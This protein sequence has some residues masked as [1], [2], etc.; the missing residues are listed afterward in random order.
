M[1]S[2]ND[3]V[4]ALDGVRI[5]DFTQVMMGPLATQS[6]GD[7]G[8]NVIKVERPGSGDIFRWAVTDEAG[9]DHPAFLG[10]N[11][12]KRSITI[13]LS[14]ETGHQLALDLA[15][16]S[17]VVINNFRPGIMDKLGLDYETLKTE[18]PR[19]IFA[20]GSG[21][22]TTG[23]YVAKGG[24]DILAQAMT[25]VMARKQDPS[26]PTAIYPTSLADYSAGMHL[27]QGILLALLARERTGRGQYLEVS[28]YDALLAMQSLEAPVVNSRDYDL[29][30]AAFPL[31]GVFPTSD[32]ELVLVGAF[33]KNPLQLICMALSLVDLSLDPR[34]D[35]NESQTV[36]KAEL[37]SLMAA[38]FATNT[39][40]FWIQQLEAQDLLCAPV[41]S[42]SEALADQQTSIND[43]LY[44]VN[45]PSAGHIQ[46]VGSPVHLRDTP[47]MLRL[48]PPM[49]GQHT[50]EVLREFGITQERIDAL[51]AQGVVA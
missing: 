19:L 7:F 30:W 29:N 22:G 11:R 27:V 17:D 10:I 28:L 12:N 3:N 39:T 23:P 50:D 37:Q 40:E 9:L 5:L 49:L 4:A 26:H 18:N 21:F 34:F 35:T 45:H 46:V 15:R 47:P 25:G 1:T 36:N 6:L 16:N 24:Q 42:L 51:H 14:N 2:T 20:Q 38:Q 43:M 44:D 32:G 33:K 48:P 8:A 13:D 41:R 31:T